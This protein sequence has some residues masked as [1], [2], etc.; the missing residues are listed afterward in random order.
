MFFILSFCIYFF[1]KKCFFASFFWTTSFFFSFYK[2]LFFLHLF[3]FLFLSSG[4][5]SPLIFLKKTSVFHLPFSFP[6][7]S[8]ISSF[9]FFEH[10]SFLVPF[11]LPSGYTCSW[12]LLLFFELFWT[13]FAS[14]FFLFFQ[15]LE[16]KKTFVFETSHHF[17]RCLKKKLMIFENVFDI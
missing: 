7:F 12:F 15:P 11:F 16:P 17:L 3:L 4:L 8:L 10:R 14:P 5:S 9:F 2:P 1:A 6:F 13:L